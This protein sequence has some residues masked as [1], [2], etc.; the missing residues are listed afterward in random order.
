DIKD[1]GG[2]VDISA[3][4]DIVAEK[5]VDE[6]IVPADIDTDGEDI[7]LNAGGDISVGFLTT[8]GLDFAFGSKV[9]LVAETG[10]IQVGYI[11]AG[12]GGIDITAG[13]SFRA[14]DSVSRGFGLQP[15]TVNDPQLV[16]FLVEQGYSREAVLAGNV[17]L[18]DTGLE[19]SL[20]TRPNGNFVPEGGLNAPV[21]IR[22]GDAARTIA[23]VEVDI[24]GTPSRILI[25]GDSQ[26]A[27]VS[28]PAFEEGQEFVP[29][30]PGDNLEDFDPANPFLFTRGEGTPY[31]Y[32]SEEFPANASG[33]AAGIAIGS[34]SD[35]SLYGSLQS[36][37]FEEVDDGGIDGGGGG[38]GG[39]GTGDGGT[40]DDEVPTVAE[41]PQSVEQI[42]NGGNPN[43]CDE[44]PD[45]IVA[46]NDILSIDE[47]LVA[48]ARSAPS[49]QISNCGA[50]EEEPIEN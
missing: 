25:Q 15:F 27:F 16:D 10:D 48:D 8:G 33:L 42:E 6:Q 2:Y 18:G 23:D 5:I 29:F 32:P 4:G 38:T 21:I 20:S 30:D 36:Q 35:N 44:D 7:T 17:V 37:L 31:S 22:Y 41:V 43:I 13:E 26:Q 12:A 34:G 40:N 47:E 11:D 50:E 46:T 9:Q 19:V 28:G 49:Q 1:F 3:G 39:D 45:N 24:N 14:I